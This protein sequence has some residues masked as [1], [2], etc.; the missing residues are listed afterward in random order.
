MNNILLRQLDGQRTPLEATV[1]QFGVTEGYK[2]YIRTVLLTHITTA[3]GT[4]QLDE[5]WCALTQGLK[6]L[7]LQPGDRIA[8]CARVKLVRTRTRRYF[9]VTS[10]LEGRPVTLNRPTHLR[11]ILLSEAEATH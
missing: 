2:G 6:A 11:I 4:P 8:F 5:Y 7:R 10:V 3:D 9:R 1:T